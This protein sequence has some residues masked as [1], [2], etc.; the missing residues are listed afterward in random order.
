MNQTDE[1]PMKPRW[2]VIVEIALSFALFYALLTVFVGFTS[3]L[4]LIG[5]PPLWAM[6]LA[7]LVLLLVVHGLILPNWKTKK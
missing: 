7:A 2:F 4:K 1:K 6:I 3:G 5:V